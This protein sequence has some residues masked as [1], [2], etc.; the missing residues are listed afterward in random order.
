[1]VNIVDCLTNLQAT[2]YQSPEDSSI[3][4]SVYGLAKRMNNILMKKVRCLFLLAM[5]PGS[6]SGD[7]LLIA[8]HVINLYLAIAFKSDVRSEVWYEKD[9]SYNN[10]RVAIVYFLKI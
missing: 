9:F 6:F 10:L 2:R 4:S 1:M 3:N 7:A 5:L 8:S